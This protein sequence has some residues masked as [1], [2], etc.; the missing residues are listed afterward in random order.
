[1]KKERA[2]AIEYALEYHTRCN[3]Q[4]I[5]LYIFVCFYITQKTL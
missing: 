2:K 1:M 5:P 4:R 3:T